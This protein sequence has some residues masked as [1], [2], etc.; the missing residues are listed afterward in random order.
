MLPQEAATPLTLE[1][2][3]ELSH[4]LA[5]ADVKLRELMNLVAGIYGPQSAPALKFGNVLQA[6]GLL[7]RDMKAQAALDCPGA[8]D[9]RL[10]Q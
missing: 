3:R 6:L 10:Y 5:A 4:E 9:E 1:E 8:A 2:H 7:R